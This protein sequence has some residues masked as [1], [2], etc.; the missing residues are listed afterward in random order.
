MIGRECLL[1][2]HDLTIDKIE[3]FF[4]IIIKMLCLSIKSTATVIECRYEHR[5]LHSK[6]YNIDKWLDQN[7]HWKGEG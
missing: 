5:L 7:T 1:R 4:S 6:V 2:G 3:L